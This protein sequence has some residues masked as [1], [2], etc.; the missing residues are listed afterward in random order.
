MANGG[1]TETSFHEAYGITVR[2]LER[3]I[4]V[5]VGRDVIR[6]CPV[7]A[8]RQG[9]DAH[10]RRA[11]RLSEAEADAL[12]ADL[13]ILMGRS[14]EAATRARRHSQESRARILPLPS[15]ERCTCAK[16]GPPKAWTT[17]SAP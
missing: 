4:Q 13:L 8:L 6:V 16:A 15:W 5:Y 9:H 1:A 7:R 10:R 2:E 3:E 11:T 12:I 17:F 14:E